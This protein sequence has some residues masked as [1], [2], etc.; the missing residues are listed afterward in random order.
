MGRLIALC[1]VSSISVFPACAPANTAAGARLPV[2]A[3]GY[4]VLE[5]IYSFNI[6]GGLED[7]RRMEQLQPAHPLGYLLE[8]EA[9]WWRIWCTSMEFK[10]GM[11]DAHHRAKLATDQHFFDVAQKISSLAEEQLKIQESAEM[12]FYDGMGQAMAARLYGLR[13][14]ARN[15]A[16]AGVR[17]REQF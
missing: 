1:L 15:T 13:G 14:E 3:E 6:E 5:K 12:H 8:A 17:A 16:R 2:P 9:L 11:N 10:Y 4:A 7:A